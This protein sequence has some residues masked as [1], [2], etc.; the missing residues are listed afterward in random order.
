MSVPAE[1]QATRQRVE[2]FNRQREVIYGL[3]WIAA[4]LLLGVFSKFVDPPPPAWAASGLQTFISDITSGF[5]IWI[6]LGT[7]VSVYAQRPGSAALVTPLFFF[8]MLLSY[9]TFSLY[10][11]HFYIGYVVRGWSIM[12]LLTIVAGYFVWYAKGE[13]LLSIVCAAVPVGLLVAHALPTYS[14][15]KLSYLLD[16][17]FAL[18]LIL[19]VQ[20]ETKPRLQTAVIGILLGGLL[21]LIPFYSIVFGALL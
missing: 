6:L 7:I 4:G 8:A 19:V 14:N 3:A 2:P 21:T 5:G 12:A 1:K 9:Y 11:Y 13:G 10:F 17:V 16:L 15:Y 20:R 18:V